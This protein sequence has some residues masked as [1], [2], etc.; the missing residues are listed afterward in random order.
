MSNHRPT[1]SKKLSRII[2]I[3][4]I[5][6]FILSLGAFYRYAKE[7]IHKEAM[8][9]SSTILNSTVQLVENYLSTIETAANANAWMLEENFNPD[10]LQVISRRIVSLNK[11]VLSCSVSAE[12]DAFPEYGRY[13]SVYSVNEG[14]TVISVMEPEFEYFEKN[15]YK[16]PTQTGHPCWINPFSDFNEGTINHHDAVGSY[17]IP[18]RPKKGHIMGVV[19]MD[20]SFE[21]LRKTVLATHHPYPSSYYM[22]LGP[23]GGY[24]IHPESSL[25]FKKSIFS[26]TDS[27]EHPDIIQLGRAMTG[28]RTGTMHV[29]LDNRLCHVCYTPV[30]GTGWSIALVC[31]EDDVL[32]DYKHLTLI[33]LAFV[34]VGILLITWI[35][36]RV[37]QHN[38]GHLNELMKA[39]NQIAEGN[40]DTIIPVSDHKGVIGSLQ[41]AFR[42]MQLAIISHTKAVQET[43]EQIM[44][45]TTELENALPRAKE[46]AKRKQLFIQSVSR[47]FNMPLNVING[48]TSVLLA[49]LNNKTPGNATTN[50]I[51]DRM[52]AS[53]LASTMKHNAYLLL[54]MTRMLY[55]SS[56]TGTADSQQHEQNDVIVCNTWAREIINL[57]M[58]RYQTKDIRFTTEVPDDFTIRTNRHYLEFTIGE[59]LMNATKFSNGYHIGFNISRT[60]TT[61]R[62]TIED[63][64]PGLPKD[65]E[66][67]FVPFA[68]VNDLSEGLGL[69][70]PL[71][72]RHISMLGG[73]LIYDPS[74]EQGCRFII[75]LKLD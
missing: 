62:L 49:D 75:E 60:E 54:R 41:N 21:K 15:W 40:Y 66:V 42:E 28:G 48:L 39:T 32:K 22:V 64:G 17:C 34:I 25:L 5:P 57:S 8:E 58:S 73:N 69:G 23:A 37:V 46:V 2:M 27:I 56:E 68:K 3:L 55:D 53:N 31:Q 52:G 50:D 70:L 6:L 72:K 10:S 74:Y 29:N 24:L 18:L 12:P 36:R 30:P 33:M 14:D 65:S 71:C 7:L 43:D 51:S 38:I 63:I 16:I 19:S 9:R 61:V 44:R 4:S 13:F 67:L 11:S 20:F 45:E 26:A 59:L 35:T 1:L 47:Q